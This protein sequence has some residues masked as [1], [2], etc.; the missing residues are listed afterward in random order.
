MWFDLVHGIVDC[1]VAAVSSCRN[2]MVMFPFVCSY[3]S[4]R[5]R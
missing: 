5:V 2:I 3:D 1:V 4:L